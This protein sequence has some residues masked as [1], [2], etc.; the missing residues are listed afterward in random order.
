[1]SKDCPKGRFCIANQLHQ[2]D[3]SW[4]TSI[5]YIVWTANNLI[6]G[7]VAPKKF[8]KVFDGGI[9]L[10]PGRVHLDVDAGIRLVK[11]PLRRVPVSVIERLE[12]ELYRLEQ[13]GVIRRVE[14]PFECVSGSVVAE[15]KNGLLRVCIDPKPLNKAWHGLGLL[16]SSPL[17]RK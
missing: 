6:D 14:E 5:T 13:W 17:L 8:Q 9:G 1:M 11:I 15:K 2:L 16:N 4:I 7:K 10:F 3:I 12:E